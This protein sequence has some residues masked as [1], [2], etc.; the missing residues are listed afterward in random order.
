MPGPPAKMK[1]LLILE[2][3]SWT[4]PAVH[5]FTWK[6]ESDILWVIAGISKTLAHSE[7]DTY[8]ESWVIQNPGIFRAGGILQAWSNIY[9]RALWEAANGYNYFCKL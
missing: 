9:D 4:F 2:E 1:V 8:S 7:T 5:Y 3:I 6:L